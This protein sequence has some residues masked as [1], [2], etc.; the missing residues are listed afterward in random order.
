MGT[1]YLRNLRSGVAITRADLAHVAARL[2]INAVYGTSMFPGLAQQA[3]EGLPVITPFRVIAYADA[4][5]I[6][7]DFTAQPFVEHV[8][9]AAEG[10]FQSQHYGPV[11]LRQLSDG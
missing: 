5:F 11:A 2:E 8:L 10:H 7:T 9:V 3:G 6:F 1:A 4:K